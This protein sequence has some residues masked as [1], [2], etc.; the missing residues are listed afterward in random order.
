VDEQ[1]SI[2]VTNPTT[3]LMIPDSNVGHDP[4]ILAQILM[5]F[6]SFSRRT[7]DNGLQKVP[8]PSLIVFF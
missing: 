8:Y 2:A 3:I 6:L 4:N 1:V 7:A 5:I